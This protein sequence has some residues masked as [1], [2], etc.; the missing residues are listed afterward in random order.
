MISIAEN[1]LKTLRDENPSISGAYLQSDEGACYHNNMTVAACQDISKLT[2]VKILGYHFSEPGQGKDICDRIICPMESALKKFGNEGNDILT[3]SDMRRA[4]KERQVS[5]TTACVSRID[6]ADN[7]LVIKKIN[8]FSTFHNFQYDS[9]GI[10]LWKAYGIGEGK[11]T[12]NDSVF[13]S[14]LERSSLL[15]GVEGQNFFE[16]K[17]IRELKIKDKDTQQKPSDIMLYECP[18]PGC[19]QAFDSLNQ[20]ELHLDLGNHQQDMQAE[21]NSLYDNIRRD[22]ACKFANISNLKLPSKSNTQSL[23]LG[24]STE[25]FQG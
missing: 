19:K 4:L 12:R 10:R 24:E 20:L 11:F 16:N 23:I 7:S 17:S 25:S 9:Y 6:K 15:E 1:I 5:G 18:Q 3:A 2:G 21:S 8:G 13:S 14:H 22:W